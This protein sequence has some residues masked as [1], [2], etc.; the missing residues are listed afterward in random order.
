VAVLLQHR[1]PE[2]HAADVDTEAYVKMRVNRMRVQYKSWLRVLAM[3]RF[4]LSLVIFLSLG[5]LNMGLVIS[6]SL[7]EDIVESGFSLMIP[8]AVG[9][10]GLAATIMSA[11]APQELVT[12]LGSALVALDSLDLWWRTSDVRDRHT[13]EAQR[14]LAF[15]VE[16]AARAV[17]GAYAQSTSVP[18]DPED[19]AELRVAQLNAAISSSRRSLQ[20]SRASSVA[21]TPS[22]LMSE[23]GSISVR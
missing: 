22:D 14:R 5:G 2:D 13:P 15:T 20:V 17:A 7:G 6:T 12:V 21:A 19:E 16:G 3:R 9:L 23:L 1:E 4:M 10:A 11:V 8:M 18:D